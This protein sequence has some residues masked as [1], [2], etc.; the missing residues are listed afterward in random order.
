MNLY[1][2]KCVLIDTLPKDYIRI[3]LHKGVLTKKGKPL[4]LKHLLDLRIQ[5]LYKCLLDVDYENLEKCVL[6][7]TQSNLYSLT[8][9]KFK[10]LPNSKVVNYSKK[11]L[12]NKCVFNLHTLK[13]FRRGYDKDRPKDLN[14][15][16]VTS[17]LDE[18]TSLKSNV[19]HTL[20]KNIRSR[21]D[22]LES[23]DYKSMSYIDTQLFK[24]DYALYFDIERDNRLKHFIYYC[25]NKSNL[26]IIE[27]EIRLYFK[28]HKP[29][30]YRKFEQSNNSTFTID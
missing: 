26:K 11:I 22:M 30:I 6:I 8:H 24:S 17:Y 23:F 3:D 28:T 25:I 14:R 9:T 2:T 1:G 5:H 10:S 19:I 18:H 15:I 13:F 21:Y 12:K 27:D 4:T 16:L 29:N 20:L 7:V